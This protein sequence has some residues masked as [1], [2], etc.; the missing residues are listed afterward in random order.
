MW[1]NLPHILALNI[2]LNQ[3]IKIPEL[4]PANADKQAFTKSTKHLT[5]RFKIT[6]VH[7]FTFHLYMW[8]LQPN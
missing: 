3:Q 4:K 5:L 8:L 6:M 7:S 1:E 2:C